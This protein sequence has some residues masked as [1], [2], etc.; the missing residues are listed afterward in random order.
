LLPFWQ[1]AEA[2]FRPCPCGGSFRFMNPPR[3][4][5]CKGLLYGDCYEDKPILRMRAGYVFVTTDSINA[6]QHLISNAA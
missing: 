3:C 5:L 6:E 1:R 4:P 2:L